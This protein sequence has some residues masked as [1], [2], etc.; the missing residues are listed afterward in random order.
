VT[1]GAA[2]KPAVP[3]APS[4]DR[5]AEQ[6]RVEQH[7]ERAERLAAP[8]R[9]ESDE[10]HVAATVLHVQRGRVVMKVFLA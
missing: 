8:L 6:R 9:P 7:A 5:P 1:F 10:H 4:A 3:A 2:Q